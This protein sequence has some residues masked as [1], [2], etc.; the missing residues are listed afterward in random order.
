MALAFARAR[1]SVVIIGGGRP[2]NAPAR[3]ALKGIN[4]LGLLARGRSDAA[5]YGAEFISSQI[6]ESV[7]T[8]D[9]FRVAVDHGRVIL[10]RKLLIATGVIEELPDFVGLRERWGRDVVHGQYCHGW[11]I[12]GKKIGL[13]ATGPMSAMQA[14]L[15]RQWSDFVQFFTQGLEFSAEELAAVGIRIATEAIAGVEVSDDRLV[16]VDL[17]DGKFIDLDALAVSSLTRAR[18]DGFEKLGLE[19]DINAAGTTLVADA[20]GHTSVPGVWGAGNVV[21]SG[22]QVSEAAGSGARV[23][24]TINTE[25][26]FEDADR[27][28][29]QTRTTGQG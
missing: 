17:Q 23:A 9:G 29:E 21:N 15:F 10:A 24:M 12:R 11:E 13:L 26:V 22:V 27:A 14:L 1:R 6:A 3:A 20:L 19:A 5:I 8:G 18:I 16:G 25:L 2:R 7:V 28:V 4:P